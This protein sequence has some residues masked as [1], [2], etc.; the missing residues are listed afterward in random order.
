MPL[1]DR[2]PLRAAEARVRELE[3]EL[4]SARRD[5]AAVAQDRKY[6]ALQALRL[7]R[8]NML[9]SAALCGASGRVAPMQSHAM[10]QEETAVLELKM[11]RWAV[12]DRVQLL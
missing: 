6:W 10:W 9:L 1:A 8:A 7:K 3:R 11:E 5:C 4:D 2:D 12:Q